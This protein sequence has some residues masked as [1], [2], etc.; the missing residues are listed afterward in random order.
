M[1]RSLFFCSIAFL[2]L[3]SVCIFFG[4]NDRVEATE[5]QMSVTLIKFKQPEYKNYILANKF[6]GDDYICGMR[7]NKCELPI[8]EAGFS[9]YWEL[10][11]N[12]LLV[13]WKWYLFPY[14][15]NL[16]LLT[17]LTW[18]QFEVD[19]SKISRV[20]TWSLSE[21]YITDPIENVYYIKVDNLEKYSNSTYG[22]EM[23]SLIDRT[24]KEES[25]NQLKE[26]NCI[27]EMADVY[28]NI[29]ALLQADLSTAIQ[30]GDLEQVKDAK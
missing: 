17:D 16:V 12:W 15:A 6:K 9:P 25:Y 20:P 30:N 1:K 11:D 28:D 19:S 5:P 21:P 8:G 26:G 27:C 2:F 18:E 13:D 29:W 7:F 24:F 14:N 3:V 22:Q 23:K 4:C 10:P